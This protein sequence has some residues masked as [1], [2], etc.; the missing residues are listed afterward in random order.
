MK[1]E[2]TPAR[3]HLAVAHAE[4]EAL[5][6]ESDLAKIFLL[7]AQLLVATAQD[8]QAAYTRAIE[9]FRKLN[10][11]RDADQAS[12]ELAAWKSR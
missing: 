3:Q 4:A 5:N 7:D 12:G 8:P 11:N 10:R 9:L 1:Q 6:Y 2:W